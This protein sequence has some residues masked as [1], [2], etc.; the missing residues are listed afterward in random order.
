MQVEFES[1]LDN[2]QIL[3]CYMSVDGV[4]CSICEPTLFSRKWFSHKLN[5]AG[6]RYEIGASIQSGSIVW[7][8][9]PWPC[10]RY[11]DISIFR[12]G[13]KH[14][15]L[16]DEFVVADSGYT[17]LRCV[18]PPGPHHPENARLALVRARHE[19]IN[20]RLKSFAV[21]SSRFR[22]HLDLHSSCFMAVLNVTVLLYADCPPF[23]IL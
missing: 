10:G 23:T 17:D 19:C 13:L 7:A 2:A 3:N 20:G 18:Q 9:G 12:S 4:D 8:S 6:L 15:L 22:H 16:D 1:R 5:R 11:S 21:L 14:K